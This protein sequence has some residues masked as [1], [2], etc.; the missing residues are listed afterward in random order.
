M[1]LEKISV[2]GKLRLHRCYTKQV[3]MYI[4]IYIILICSHIILVLSAKYLCR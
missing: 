2:E 1:I 4:Y 3:K